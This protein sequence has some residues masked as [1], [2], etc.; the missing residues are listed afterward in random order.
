MIAG[1]PCTSARIGARGEATHGR[2]SLL[3]CVWLM[4]WRYE[5]VELLMAAPKEQDAIDW[6]GWRRMFGRAGDEIAERVCI[7]GLWHELETRNGA[8]G[9]RQVRNSSNDCWELR[10][11]AL[12][13]DITNHHVIH[14]YE[15]MYDK[16]SLHAERH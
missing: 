10:G 12:A 9:G 1:C 11:L 3:V 14:L 13:A 15:S 4:R 8:G 7:C 2:Y 16:D 6:W 5:A